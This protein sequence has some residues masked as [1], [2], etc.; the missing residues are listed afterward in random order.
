MESILGR[1]YRC[2]YCHKPVIEEDI[3][4][5]GCVCGS[6][7]ISIVTALTDEEVVE[8]KE[9]GY[10]FD[11]KRWMSRETADKERRLAATA[12][13]SKQRVEPEVQE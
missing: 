8:L 9:R 11:D 7:R 13:K 3:A 6:R 4:L 5:G 1:V 10:E 2:E 12:E